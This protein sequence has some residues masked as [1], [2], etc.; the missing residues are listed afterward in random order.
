LQL[1]VLRQGLKSD[2]NDAK[3]LALLFGSD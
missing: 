1:I 3:F 2:F